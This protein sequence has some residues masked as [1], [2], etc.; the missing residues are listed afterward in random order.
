MIIKN[1]RAKIIL[2]TL[3]L[4]TIIWGCQKDEF[5]TRPQLEFVSASLSTWAPGENMVFTLKFTDKEGDIFGPLDLIFD[6]ILYVEKITRNCPASDFSAYYELPDAPDEDFSEGELL[7]RYSL[8]PATEF[9]A[10]KDPQCENR[11]D[12]CVFRFVLRD[13]AGNVSDT[14]TSPE[15]VLIDR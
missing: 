8:F 4:V 6:T 15:I 1:M 13:R 5:T 2:I 3:L 12:S 7:V 9:P 11:N 14:V 10:V